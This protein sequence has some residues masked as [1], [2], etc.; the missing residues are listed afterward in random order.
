MLIY[1]MKTETV[2]IMKKLSFLDHLVILMLE[3]SA[4]STLLKIN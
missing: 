3:S 2:V 1:G 4:L